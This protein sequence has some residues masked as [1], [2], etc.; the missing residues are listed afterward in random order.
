MAEKRYAHLHPFTS[1]SIW[2]TAMGSGAQFEPANGVRTQALMLGNCFINADNGYG[3]AMNIAKESDPIKTVT[4]QGITYTHRIP[5]GAIIVDGTDANL[6]V[7]DGRTVYEYWLAEPDGSGNYVAGYGTDTDLLGS[8]INVGIRAAEFSTN[9]GLIRKHEL[10]NLHIP[11]AL[12]MALANNQLKSGQVFP[13]RSQ[14]WDGSTVYTGEIPMGSLFAIPPSVNIG[15]LGL[16]PEG[17]ALAQALQD[18]GVYVGDRASQTVLYGSDDAEQDLKPE[19]N[20]MVDDWRNIIRG[21]L[22]FVTN[23]TSTTVGGG[24]ARRQ[25]ALPPVE[26]YIAPEP[27]PEPEPQPKVKIAEIYVSSGEKIPVF[28]IEGHQDE[29]IRVVTPSGIGF[30]DTV[31][32]GDPEASSIRMNTHKGLMAWRKLIEDLWHVLDGGIFTDTTTGELYDGD[33]FT[34]TVFARTFDA[35]AF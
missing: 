7:I 26:V 19:F 29:I 13:A 31:A 33:S 28:N 32:L 34:N 3:I 9:A 35:G 11:H 15:S 10:E 8:G 2:N 24:G 20:R 23:S 30:I 18:Y 27:E 17:L 22:R 5:D 6:N 25:P 14:D 1:D 12:V 4:F 16:S 21:Q